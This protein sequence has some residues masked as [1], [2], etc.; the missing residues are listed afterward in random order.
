MCVLWHLASAPSIFAP[1]LL[2]GERRESSCRGVCAVHPL[3]QLSGETRLA[4]QDRQAHTIDADLAA[5]LLPSG[6]STVPASTSCVESSL[7]TRS[8]QVLQGLEVCGLLFWGVGTAVLFTALQV[9][10]ILTWD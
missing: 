3:G 6:Q 2:H 1:C 5:L 4:G 7:E 8:P 9:A 10:G